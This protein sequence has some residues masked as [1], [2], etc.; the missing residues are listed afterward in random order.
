MRGEIIYKILNFLKNGARNQIDFANAFL[1]TGYGATSGKIN[2]ELRKIQ[3][4]RSEKEQQRNRILKLQKY[5]SKLK[6]DGLIFESKSR[7]IYLSEMGKKK[8]NNFQNQVSS[9]KYLHNKKTSEKVTVVSYDIPIVFN[10]ERRILRDILRTLGFNL[11]H[12][13]V[14]VGKVALPERFIIDLGRLRII[15]YVEILEVT[16][17]GT[18]KSKN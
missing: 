15:D 11:V 18:L 17:N 8:L 10:K 6:H 13:S 12:K 2:Y 4:K 7:R 9:D 14:W 16:K 1:R 5:L 3:N